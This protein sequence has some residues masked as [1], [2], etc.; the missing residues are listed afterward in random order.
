MTN[1]TE[2]MA[3]FCEKIKFEILPEEVVKRAKLLILDTVG[4][5]IRARHD[6]ESTNSLISAVNKLDLNN[7]NCQVFSDKSKY[8]PSAAALINGTLAHSLDFDDTHAEASLH[9][10]APILAAAFAA[11]QMKN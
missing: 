11:A 6:A 4:I 8:V 7:G 2:K 10:S 5:I 9:S 1:V 3:E